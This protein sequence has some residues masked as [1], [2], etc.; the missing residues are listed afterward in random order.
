[1]SGVGSPLITP[2]DPF[3]ERP[4]Y[5]ELPLSRANDTVSPSASVAAIVTLPVLSL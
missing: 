2:V 1:M 4:P 5:R 3:S